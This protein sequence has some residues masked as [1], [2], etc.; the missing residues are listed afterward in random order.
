V[1][2]VIERDPPQ[3]VEGNVCPSVAEVGGI[4][5]CGAA[6]VPRRPHKGWW[7]AAIIAAVG[8]CRCPRRILRQG[9]IAR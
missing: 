8:D 9:A 3:D 5:D 1:R 4:I 7:D 6:D 2:M